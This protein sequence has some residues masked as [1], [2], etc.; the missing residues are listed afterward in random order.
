MID[1]LIVGHGPAGVSAALYAAR[2]GMQTVMVGKD[3]GA[4]AK[5]EKVENFYGHAAPVAGPDLTAAGLAQAE[6][7][8][9]SVITGEV[10]GLTLDELYTVAT[11]ADAYEARCVIL[12]TGA[13]RAKPAV[14]GLDDGLPG[15]SYCAVCDAFFHRGKDVAVLGAGPHA[16]REAMELLPL[17][18][19]VTLLT[20]GEPLTARFP[21]AVNV[22]TAPVAAVTGGSKL[23]GVL[24]ENGEALAL[25][26]LFIAAGV[27]GSADLAKKIGAVTEGSHIAVDSKMRTSVPGLWAA[28]DCTGG[29]KQIAKAVYEGAVAGTE[30]IQYVRGQN[31]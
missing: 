31:V 2:A 26:G 1:I 7:L 16:L 12:A 10:V 13:S 20:N 3:K 24:F 30:A 28:G 19:S 25:S 11:D 4:L 5:A 21:E 17:T 22:V 14:Q 15:V 23:D 8:G 9:V 18:R 6:R 29:M 27:A